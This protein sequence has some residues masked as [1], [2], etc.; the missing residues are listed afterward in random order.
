MKEVLKG[1]IA[2]SVY[3]KRKTEE[4]GCSGAFLYIQHL[5]DRDRWNSVG[6]KPAWSTL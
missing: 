3:I 4:T 1:S 5:G 6:S 2:V